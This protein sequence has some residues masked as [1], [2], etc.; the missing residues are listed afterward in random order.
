MSSFVIALFLLYGVDCSRPDLLECVV[1]E[2]DTV[3]YAKVCK[4]NVGTMWKQDAF[5]TVQVHYKGKLVQVDA[6][7]RCW[8]A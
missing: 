5:P 1:V 8:S 2:T 6:K 3:V 4:P 7:T